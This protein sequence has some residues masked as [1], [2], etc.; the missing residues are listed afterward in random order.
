MKNRFGVT[1]D[2]DKEV[3]LYWA[4]K[5]GLAN[6]IRFIITPKHEDKEKRHYFNS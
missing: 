6:L 1:V 4:P 5:D 3:F 2:A